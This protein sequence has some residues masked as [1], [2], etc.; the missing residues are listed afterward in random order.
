[1]FVIF[2]S[3]FSEKCNQL[4]NAIA[5]APLDITKIC[6]DNKK[7]R[8]YLKEQIAGVPCMFVIDESKMYRY[9]GVYDILNFIK[10]METAPANQDE[11]NQQIGGAGELPSLE[12]EMTAS[13]K[14]PR[15]L[16]LAQQMAAER[17][18]DMS[19]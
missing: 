3:K 15:I 4:F 17:E 11:E 12:E 18:K 7:V 5:G 1:M 9:D 8:K 10:S 16:D 6:V 19:N 14:N 2:Y 13:G